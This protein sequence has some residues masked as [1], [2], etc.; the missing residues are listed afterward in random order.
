MM[1]LS[2]P[3]VLPADVYDALEFGALTVDGIGG[4]EFFEVG[5]GGYTYDPNKPVCAIGLANFLDGDGVGEVT[6][7]LNTAGIYP[8]LSDH[9]VYNVNMRRGVVR[10]AETARVP[11]PDWASELGI[12]RGVH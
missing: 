1:N 7:A 2:K 11:F 6:R 10:D 3:R 9:A 12:T 4:K 8:S 5:K